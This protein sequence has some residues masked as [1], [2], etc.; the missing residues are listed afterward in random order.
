MRLS[1]Y[2]IRYWSCSKFA[3]LIR[4]ENKPYALEWGQWEKWKDEQKQKRPLRYWLSDTVL[5]KVQDI[6]YFPYDLYHTIRIYIRNRYIDKIHY[7][8]TGLKPGEYYDLDYRIIHALFNEL[9]DFV[10]KELSHLSKWEKNKKYKFKN[11]RCVEAAYDYFKY[12]EDN[13][14]EARMVALKEPKTSAFFARHMDMLDV[15]KKDLN[16]TN[17]IKKLYEW[18]TITRPNRVSPYSDNSLGDIDDILD[19]KK[20][21]TN[22]LRIQKSIDLEEEY[23]K[24][25]TKMLIELIKIRGSL[26]T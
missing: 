26:W 10:E 11:G 1:K 22:K 17:K 24:E 16:T 21:K 7:L 15:T 23:N 14:N 3:N 18:W 19:I 5:N 20:T 4:G 25:D 2:R 8:H 6:V 12:V 9:V 13:F